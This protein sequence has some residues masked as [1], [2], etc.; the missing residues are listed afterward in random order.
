MAGNLAG[1]TI[2]IT[3]ATSGIGATAARALIAQG[4]T[5]VPVGR[6]AQRA[7]ALSEQ[8]GV[9]TLVADYARFTDVRRLAAELQDRCPTVD[10]LVHNAGGVVNGRQ[11]TE[12]GHEMTLQTNYLAPYLLQALLHDRLAASRANV[13]VTSSAAHRSG[14]IRLDDL[15][16]DKRRY[17]AGL[18]YAA[19]KLADLLFSRELAHR[20]KETGITS[21]A[22]HPGTVT[23]DFSRDAKGVNKFVYHTRAGRR[24]FGA[25]DN[26]AGAQPLIA[27]A[28]L[29]DPQRVNGQYFDRLKPDAP[30]SKQ[31]QDAALATR[32]WETTADM[33][34][35]PAMS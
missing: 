18:A 24:L 19:A 31:A 32:L 10:V 2:V 21:V 4:A 13:V 25:V 6:S 9:E 30:T 14:R 8:L 1:K 35:L 15:E 16:Y 3:G 33:L 27:L 20:A 23:S 5:V 7:A 28:G 34:G 22:F 29:S 11:R 12:D 26:D 17:V